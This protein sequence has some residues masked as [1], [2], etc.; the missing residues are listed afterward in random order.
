MKLY[1]TTEFSK[2]ITSSKN[3]IEITDLMEYVFINA[4]AIIKTYG[5]SYYNLLTYSITEKMRQFDY[6]N[7]TAN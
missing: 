3:E 1:T 7:S 5:C 2:I 4:V 6:D